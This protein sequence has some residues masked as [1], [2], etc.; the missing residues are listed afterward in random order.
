MRR[1][2]SL[3]DT[4]STAGAKPAAVTTMRAPPGTLAFSSKRPSLPV[5]GF[6]RCG[7][8]HVEPDNRVRDGGSRR[9]DDGPVEETG[10]AERAG[11]QK[12][13]ENKSLHRKVCRCRTAKRVT[14]KR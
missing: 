8:G 1:L 3:S 9:I 6:G 12:K 11:I 7:A 2:A 4:G 5:L 13:G 14:S 10:L